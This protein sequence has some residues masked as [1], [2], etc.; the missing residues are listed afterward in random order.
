MRIEIPKQVNQEIRKWLSVN[1]SGYFLTNSTPR[2][3]PISANDITKLLTKIF[4]EHTG[5]NVNTSMIR[6]IY[7]SSKYKGDIEVDK[8]KQKDA[9]NLCHSLQQQK[10]YVKL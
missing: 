5:K 1:T 2:V 3:E 6:H 9:H 7:L 4:Q 10:D 8:V